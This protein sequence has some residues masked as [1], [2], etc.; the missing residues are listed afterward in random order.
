VFYLACTLNS[1]HSIHA[2]FR[3]TCF[4]LGAC[5]GFLSLIANSYSWKK[6]TAKHKGAG[7][8]GSDEHLQSS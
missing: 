2:A 7:D 1:M 8:G 6:T 5:S 4:V 3:L